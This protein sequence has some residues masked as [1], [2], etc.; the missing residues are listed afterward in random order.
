MKLIKVNVYNSPYKRYIP[1]KK[2]KYA[3]NQKRNT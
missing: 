2:G 3:K 1:I